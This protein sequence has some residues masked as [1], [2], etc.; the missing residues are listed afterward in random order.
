MAKDRLG[1]HYSKSKS[2]DKFDSLADSA[3]TDDELAEEKDIID[4][5]PKVEA[6]KAD[7]KT[8]RND[9]CPCGSGKKYKKCCALK[10]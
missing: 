3:K 8:G 1:E 7:A 9:P 5:T 2:K 4:K 10:E 6:I